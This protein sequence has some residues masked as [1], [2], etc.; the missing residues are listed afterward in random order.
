MELEATKA[1]TKK[2]IKKEL[3]D[4]KFVK[5]EE[6]QE[7]LEQLREQ[8]NYMQTKHNDNSIHLQ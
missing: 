3:Q 8:M 4:C 7:Q 6:L 1:Q 2:D 5:D